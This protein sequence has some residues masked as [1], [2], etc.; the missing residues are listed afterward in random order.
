[1]TVLLSL[2]I[3][4]WL[5]YN[6]Q[7]LIQANIILSTKTGSMFRLPSQRNICPYN[8]YSW[9]FQSFENRLV[10]IEQVLAGELVP[11]AH[12]SSEL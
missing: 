5:N 11:L 6:Q 9:S 10:F 2:F 4:Y 12:S 1:M 8:I 7:N 3:P